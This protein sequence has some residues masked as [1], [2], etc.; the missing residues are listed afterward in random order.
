MLRITVELVPHGDE[1]RKRII[2]VGEIVNDGTA[3]DGS[4]DSSMGNYVAK[5]F[6]S[7][8]FST[9][10]GVWRQC[11]VLGFPRKKLGPW[12]LLYR[13]LKESVGYRNK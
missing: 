7:P 13:V 3:S 4:G 6:K 1:S 5:L 10:E 9:A 12:D 2:G 8:E 11:P